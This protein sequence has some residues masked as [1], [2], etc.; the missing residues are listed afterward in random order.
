M[1]T[2]NDS[3]MGKGLDTAL[4]VLC[5]SGFLGILLDL[6]HLISLLVRG[7]MDRSAHTGGFIV[8]Y[9]GFLL[10]VAYLIGLLIRRTKWY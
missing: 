6:D 1:N 2:V 4:R 10:G 9:V 7:R 8:S 3:D 5:T